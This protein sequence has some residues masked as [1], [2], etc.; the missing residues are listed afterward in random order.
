M[1]SK[2]LRDAF[3]STIWTKVAYLFARPALNK[4]RDHFDP[5]LYNGAMFLGINGVVV[6]SHGGTDALGFCSAINAAVELVKQG[7]NERIIDEMSSVTGGEAA[8][9]VAV[10]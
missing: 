7:T 8:A 5:R 9:A 1:F 10:K 6:K 4:L 2:A 3:T